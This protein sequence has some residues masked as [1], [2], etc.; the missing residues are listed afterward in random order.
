MAIKAQIYTCHC[1]FTSA[2]R[3][4]GYL[5]STLR[6]ALGWALKKTSCALRRQQ[7]ADCL[8]REQCAYAWIFET[9]S[10]R[11]REGHRVNARPHPFVL[12]PGE[13]VAG[14]KN[15]GDTLAF[16]L[17]LL[18]RAN[19]LLPQVVYA[20]Q[21]MGKSGIGSGRRHGM[22]R[23]VLQQVAARGQS[24]YSAENEV[25]CQPEKINRLRL[26]NPDDAPVSWI[27]VDLAT[28]LRLKQSNRLNH[29]LPFHILVRACLRR[30]AALENAYG[31]GEPLLDYHGLVN[32]ARQVQTAAEDIHWQKL[33]RWSSRQ[34][35][36][37]SLSGLAGSITYRGE[38]RDYLPIL[39]YAQ[40][41][42]IGKQTMFGLGKFRLTL[43][44]KN[45][46]EQKIPDNE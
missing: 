1:Q 3:L 7:C 18:D 6:G 27:Q 43:G 44:S 36:N 45:K 17:L 32:R 4:P 22:G 25:L 46:I 15:V 29:T 19:D 14:E 5:G 35:Q 11:S 33:L 40:Q 38:L 26:A 10:C 21:L 9:E 34:R 37:T 31:G 2:A 30:I 8:L 16:S 23:F 39:R 24:I 28:P 42:N 41:V 20:V 12:Q 13:V